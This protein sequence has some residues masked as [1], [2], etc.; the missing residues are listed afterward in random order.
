M[1]AITVILAAVIGTFVLGLG[2]NVQSTSPSASFGFDYEDG[3]TGST[4]FDLP[5]TVD[6]TLTITHESGDAISN[7]Q[8]EIT[9]GSN[10]EEDPFGSSTVSAGTSIDAGIDSESTVRVIWTSQSGDNSATLGTFTGPDA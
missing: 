8:L 5:S 9:D 7:S 10:T 2:E 6:G 3:A 4:D 1:V